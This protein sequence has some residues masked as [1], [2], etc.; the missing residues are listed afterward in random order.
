MTATADAILLT[1][2]GRCTTEGLTCDKKTFAQAK[3][4]DSTKAY[5]GFYSTKQI[6][7]SSFP[8]EVM[9][10]NLSVAPCMKMRHS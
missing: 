8:P 4:P 3:Y 9:L 5:P 10:V 6:E 1:Y 2:K 7:V